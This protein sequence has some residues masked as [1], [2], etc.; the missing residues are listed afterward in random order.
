M[1]HS[2]LTL[3][4]LY[5]TLTADIIRSWLRVLREVHTTSDTQLSKMKEEMNPRNAVASINLIELERYLHYYYTGERPGIIFPHLE[6][7]PLSLV[8]C[9]DVTLEINLKPG[10]HF[11][12]FMSQTNTALLAAVIV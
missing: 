7:N 6:M 3:S 1:S 5:V 10:Q 11:P 8:N 9:V 2:L 4:L 12:L